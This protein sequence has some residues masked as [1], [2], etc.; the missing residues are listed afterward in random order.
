MLVISRADYCLL[1]TNSSWYTLCL[2]KRAKFG[3]L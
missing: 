1:C 3:K 2:K